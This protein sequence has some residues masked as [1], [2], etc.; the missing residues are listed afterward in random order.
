MTLDDL[1]TESL[2]PPE[3]QAFAD[4]CRDL[5][6]D[7]ATSYAADTLRGIAASVEARGSISPAQLIAVDHIVEGARRMAAAREGR[8]EGRGG[9]RRY[10]GWGR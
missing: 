3:V 2:L 6:D 10:E 8:S 4:R 7:D 9:S 5:A 1:G